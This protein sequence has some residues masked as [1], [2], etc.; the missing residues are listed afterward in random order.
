MFHVK[1][2]DTEDELEAHERLRYDVYVNEKRWLPEGNGQH[3][4][5]T[6]SLDAQSTKLIC[7]DPQRNPAG[8]LRLIYRGFTRGD[9]PLPIER[10][11]FGCVVDQSVTS[12]EV[13]RLA[14]AAPYRGVPP[15]LLGLFRL[16]VQEMITS[17]AQNCYAVVE[18]ELLAGLHRIGFP[19]RP[20]QSP[21]WHLGG[22]VIPVHAPTADLVPGVIGAG[23]FGH[24]FSEPF[25]GFIG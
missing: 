25:D 7:F 1:T 10:E 5:E 18:S 2:V 20:L 14:V 8:V 24:L 17:S 3:Q 4:R 6:D 13:S 23:K 19:F 16:A 11:P 15:V 9:L 22:N 21:Q 12:V